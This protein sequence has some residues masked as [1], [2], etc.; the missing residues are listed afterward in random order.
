MALRIDNFSKLR[1]IHPQ[2]DEMALADFHE[3]Q[4]SYLTQM[5]TTVPDRDWKG[6]AAM[7]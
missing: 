4:P 2:D 1:I 5:T 3:L 7:F 6:L